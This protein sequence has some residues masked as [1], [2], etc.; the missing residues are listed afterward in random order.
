MDRRQKHKIRCFSNYKDFLYSLVPLQFRLRIFPDGG[1]RMGL[2]I[3]DDEDT[4]LGVW[5]GSVDADGIE[6]NKTDFSS[7]DD[8]STI[9]DLLEAGVLV[10]IVDVIFDDVTEGGV[11][12]SINPGICEMIF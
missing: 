10:T 2:E 4:R 9:T 12:W 5:W 8:G 11:D 7:D 3:V 6:L 1:V